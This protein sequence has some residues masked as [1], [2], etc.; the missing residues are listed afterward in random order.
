[1]IG[2]RNI[3]WRSLVRLMVGESDYRGLGNGVYRRA[4]RAADR[5][6]NLA[7]GAN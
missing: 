6:L 2:F 3:L 7:P 4:W 1:M 5:I